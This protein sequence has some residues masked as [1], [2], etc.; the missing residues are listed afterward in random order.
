MPAGVRA[1]GRLPIAAKVCGVASMPPGLI[2]ALHP[3]ACL[4]GSRD[5]RQP[6]G[7][8]TVG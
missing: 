7:K 2:S 3:S 8:D 6:A 4:K 1:D 5:G